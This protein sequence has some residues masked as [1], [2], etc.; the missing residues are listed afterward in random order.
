MFPLIY[1]YDVPQQVHN[2]ISTANPLIHTILIKLFAEIGK[3]LKRKYSL[4]KK[5]LKLNLRH[6]LSANKSKQKMKKN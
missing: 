3:R 1:T 5:L 6:L 4:P 2:G